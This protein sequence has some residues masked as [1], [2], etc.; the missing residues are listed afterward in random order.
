M[1]FYKF[2]IKV[3]VNSEQEKDLRGKIIVQVMSHIFEF[4]LHINFTR[5]DHSFSVQ[6]RFAS[7]PLF[8]QYCLPWIVEIRPGT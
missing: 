6:S 4:L 8:V 2:A 1:K 5:G 3:C 7:K